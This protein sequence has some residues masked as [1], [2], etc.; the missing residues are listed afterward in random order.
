MRPRERIVTLRGP[1]RP[2]LISVLIPFY[3][4][5]PTPLV[6]ALALAGDD[7]EFVLLSDG[8]AGAHDLLPLIEALTQ[9]SAPVRLIVFADNQGRSSARNRLADAALGQFLLFLDADMAPA[10]PTFLARWL[11]IARNDAPAIAFGGLRAPRHVEKSRRLHRRL[12]LLSDCHGVRT[13]NV[14]PA[15][16]LASSNLLVRRD[17]IDAV[18][19]DDGFVGWGWEDVDWALRAAQLAPITHIDNPAIHLG[20]DDVETL[21]R[22]SAEGATNFARLAARH[23]GAVKQFPSYRAARLAAHAPKLAALAAWLAR[24]PL[25][26]APLDLRVRALKLHR[27]AL[28][29]KA[30][31]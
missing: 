21:L 8:A 15:R 17:L 23:P 4:D 30:L 31:A 5:D 16:S 1:A 19:F 12:A 29:A 6:E 20:L 2:P 10:S 22:K 28:N 26:L 11:R 3:K 24:D 13:R 14:A 18:P 7:V 27:A 25:G 9:L